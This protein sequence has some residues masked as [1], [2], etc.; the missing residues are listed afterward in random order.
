ML[1]TIAFPGTR[2]RT[3][4]SDAGSPSATAPIEASA[5]ISTLTIADEMNSSR[6]ARR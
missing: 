5:A 2:P 6:P 1:S 3:K 4:A